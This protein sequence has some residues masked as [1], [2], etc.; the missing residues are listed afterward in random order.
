MNNVIKLT[1]QNMDEIVTN[2]WNSVGKYD[3]YKFI[4]DGNDIH[5]GR[6]KL[7]FVVLKLIGIRRRNYFDIEVINVDAISPMFKELGVSFPLEE[8]LRKRE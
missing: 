2:L 5:D 8:G 7:C 3:G 6:K 4:I 1:S